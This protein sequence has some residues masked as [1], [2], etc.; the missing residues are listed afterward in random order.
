MTGIA[1]RVRDAG[2]S[3]FARMTP[4]VEAGGD[5]VVV[6]QPDHLG[7]IIMAQPAVRLLR[8]HLPDTRIVGVVGPWSQVIARIAWPV[9][10][11]VTLDYPGF[12]RKASTTR[13]TAYRQMPA[14][15]QKLKALKST[16]GIVLR[17]DAWW[18][19]FVASRAMPE[20]VAGVDQAFVTRVVNVPNAEHA[21]VRAA[22]I[23]ADWLDIAVPP[24]ADLTLSIP[25]QQEAAEASTAILRS[26]SID[27][28]YAVIHPG[29]GAAVKLWTAS[30][31]RAITQYL[32]RR[33]MNVILT[34]GADERL[35]CE[36]IAEGT[37]A[38]V[39]AGET[40]IPT[41]AEIF[42]NAS[43]AL[44]TDNGPMHLAV[45]VGAPSVHLFGPSDPVRYG[46]WGDP[47]R[48]RVV[49]AGWQCPRCGDLSAQRPAGCGCMLAITVDMVR[50]EID[51]LLDLHGAD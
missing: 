10:E 40:D 13:A 26:R 7:D 27:R 45:A 50:S 22:S 31:W 24:H 34:G 33:G 42:R 3:A 9:D 37:S 38:V 39:F 16:T 8:Q 41:L 21:V 51:R 47:G 2:L 23:A 25:S 19:A 17:P 20:V 28:E 18:A 4:A 12:T 44:G 14:D 30:R 1:H 6:L 46:P 36:V 29:S 5:T 48:H 49:S 32:V 11:I 15:I 35:I 43:L